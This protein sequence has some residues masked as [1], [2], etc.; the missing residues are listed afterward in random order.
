MHT[1]FKD[2]PLLPEHYKPNLEEQSPYQK[3]LISMKIG[4]NPTDTKFIST[5]KPKENYVIDYRMLQECIKQGVILKEIK[6]VILF[7]QKA[8]LKPYIYLNTKLRQAAT[9]EF[10]K[11]CFKLMNN[12]V[13]GK[14]MDNVRNRC[15]VSLFNKYEQFEICKEFESRDVI[16]KENVLVYKKES[17]IKLNKP[18]YGGFVVLELSKIIMIKFYYNYLKLRYRKKLHY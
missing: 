3:E 5:L 10:E 4:K 13:Y 12:S 11:N 18:I 16:D 9:N 1:K 6:K 8:W 7:K 15:Q 14:Q 2:Y 17:K